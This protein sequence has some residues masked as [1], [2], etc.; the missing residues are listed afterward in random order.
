MGPTIGDELYNHLL[1]HGRMGEAKVQ[2]I[3]TQ[4]LGA[5]AYVHAKSCVHRDLKLENILLDKHGN[6]KLCDFGFTREYQGATSYLQTWCGTICYSAPEMLKGEKYAGEKVD[7]WSLGIILYALLCGELPYDEDDETETKTRILKEEPKY[8]DH[9]PEG[10]K[11]LIS[12]LLS[13]RPLL[14]PSLADI[15]RH[16]WLSEH[17]P[18]QQEILKIQQPAPFTTDLE[19]NTLQRMRSAGVDIDMVIEHVLAQRCD[20]LAGWWA[21]LMEKE[22]RKER[23]RQRKR[24]ER[25]AEARSLRRLSAASSRLLAAPSL[26]DINEEHSP[27]LVGD[28]PR[29]RGRNTSRSSAALPDLP[30]VTESRTPPPDDMPP[31]PVEKDIVRAVRSASTSRQRPAPPP[32]EYVRRPRASSRSSAL[33]QVT[34]TNNGLLAPPPF[35]QKRRRSVKDQ[36]AHIKHWFKESTK[37]NSKS[38]SSSTVTSAASSRFTPSSD[39]STSAARENLP[40]GSTSQQLDVRK[41]TN[42]HD[43][44]ELLPRNTLSSRPRVSTTSSYGSTGSRT[45]RISL[46]PAPVTPR[47]S[48]YRRSGTG[49]K[50][51][52]STSSSVSSFRSIHTHHHSHSKASSTSS[53]SLA[54]P[55]NV[56]ITS[57]PTRSPHNSV[58]VLHPGTP[59]SVTGTFPAGIRIARRPPPGSLGALPLPPFQERAVGIAPPISA[60][61][62]FGP[63]SPGLH[64]VFAKKKRSVF[65]GPFL[66][67][68]NVGGRSNGRNP[69]GINEHGGS[70]G[71]SVQGRRSGELAITEEDEEEPDEGAGMFLVTEENEDGEVVDKEGM[72]LAE[73]DEQVDGGG[74]VVE[75]VEA[76]A[77]PANDES[78]FIVEEGDESENK[79]A[80]PKDGE[81]D[82]Q[83][84]APA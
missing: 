62:P 47:S 27:V 20:S 71:S 84:A 1:K 74:M 3:F 48:V 32:K 5:V 78:V 82:K 17:A 70:R 52:K 50:G 6:V 58:K 60:F 49:L 43:R 79:E 40:R 66:G 14:R 35:H 29:T 30:R 21:L 7:V 2:K 44:S 63:S 76:F 9:L 16:P 26:K 75:E 34:H 46:S 42:S 13:K 11:D 69:A 33:L 51:R 77:T 57:R 65:K 12:K 81:E 64:P 24:K 10:A 4:L 59:T 23:R 8:P 22:E 37:R 55:S 28:P 25:D 83:A 38:P 56:S 31:P 54:S 19:K 45:H 15:L 18:Q 80:D 67:G 61:S 41:S 39:G 53:A 72:S 68:S 36:L 73:E